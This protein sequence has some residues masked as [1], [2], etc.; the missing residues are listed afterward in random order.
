MEVFA[1]PLVSAS[2]EHS[3]VEFK[4][5]SHI[6]VSFNASGLC[7][8]LTNEF[9]FWLDQLNPGIKLSFDY[10]NE[11]NLSTMIINYVFWHCISQCN[12]NI[13]D[14]K[15][16]MA[17]ASRPKSD[18]QGDRDEMVQI[19]CDPWYER[20]TRVSRETLGSGYSLISD[21]AWLL[22]SC[23]LYAHMTIH[24]VNKVTLL[25][26]KCIILLVSFPL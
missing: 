20:S 21:F 2:S 24:M 22:L 9:W 1:L 11:N 7:C 4:M 18:W 3:F 6:L 25:I 5:S 13:T 16:E 14:W 10:N 15:S 23:T 8:V 19:T 17:M 26:H 12:K